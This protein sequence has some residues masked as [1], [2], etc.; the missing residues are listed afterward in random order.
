M[1]GSVRRKRRAAENR[2]RQEMNTDSDYNETE[3]ESTGNELSKRLLM[4]TKIQ[5]NTNLLHQETTL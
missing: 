2:N 1:F 4:I 5:L 3:I